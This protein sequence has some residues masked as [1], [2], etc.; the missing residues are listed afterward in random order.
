M[1]NNK[2]WKNIDEKYV[3][4]V[5]DKILELAGSEVEVKGQYEEWKIK[6]S[7]S[8]FTLFSSK[9]GLTLYSNGSKSEDPV[10]KELYE[11][12][13]VLIGGSFKKS[14]KKYTIGLDEAGKGELVGHLFLSG[15]LIPNNILSDLDNIVG[16]ADTKNK[17]SFEYWDGIFK[18]IDN[19]R[20]RGLDFVLERIE[21]WIFDQYNV[22]KIIDVVY[23]RILNEF[24][25]RID[26]ISEVRIVLDDYGIGPSLERFL[27]FLEMQGAEVV[28]VH[29]AD[30]DY[31][32]AKVASL[33][34]KRYREVVL[35]AI[36]N[37]EQF[38]INGQSIGS[39][40]AGNPQT[41]QWLKDWHGSGKPW[42]WF[43]KKSFKTISEIEGHHRKV[44]KVM[45][46][47][48]EKIFSQDFIKSF[49]KGV[50]N[51][52]TLSIV[53][54]HCGET[55]KSIKMA[56]YYNKDNGVHVS[57]FKCSSCDKFLNDISFSL[58]Y[59]CGYILPDSN[60]VSRNV[61]TN[62]LKASRHFEHYKILMSSIV[63][64]EIDGVPRA[65]KELDEL[66][67]CFNSGIIKLENVGDDLDIANLDS[68]IKDN[69]IIKHA[70][71]Y[72]SILIT[73]DKSMATFA[74]GEGLFVIDLS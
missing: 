10:I 47:F 45:P 26:S 51:I 11:Y 12:I 40:N 72:N 6:I 36:N 67:I 21:P 28:V 24:L 25:R 62:D 15:V 55:L 71:E 20:K 34:S 19:Q 48:N 63:R 58:R 8:E 61:I 70:L 69:A 53:C 59:Y 57:D 44:E 30:D 14:E 42:P 41:L 32:E 49:E 64:K 9:K 68:A 31:L 73:G 37:N 29:K 13:E 23:Q 39:G 35:K 22:N 7:D 74:L 2:T 60:A 33:V 50:L 65:K 27:K 54:T 17:K 56:N 5:K 38:K 66:K 1:T 43:I 3:K 4:P 46:P 52:K 18:N 16:T